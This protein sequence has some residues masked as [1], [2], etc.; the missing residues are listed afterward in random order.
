M[1]NIFPCTI[2]FFQGADGHRPEEATGLRAQ[3]RRLDH[4]PQLA[5]V[6]KLAVS[7][8]EDSYPSVQDAAVYNNLSIT[9]TSTALFFLIFH[10][11]EIVMFVFFNFAMQIFFVNH[12]FAFVQAK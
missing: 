2:Y 11:S 7:V 10:I 8:F 5:V 1:R 4:D 3:G 12:F 6:S 9:N